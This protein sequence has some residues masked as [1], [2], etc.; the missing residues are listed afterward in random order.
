MKQLQQAK[1]VKVA[2]YF[3]LGFIENYLKKK[4]QH[5]PFLKSITATELSACIL[6]RYS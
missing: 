1:I 3:S 6:L 5:I 2:C 4:T